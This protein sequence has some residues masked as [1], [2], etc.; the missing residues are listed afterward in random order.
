[1]NNRPDRIRI[2]IA[3]E[4]DSVRQSIRNVLT[5][6]PGLYLIGEANN[7]SEAI[8][9]ACRL[10]PD[11][12][13]LGM[14]RCQDNGAPVLEDMK[15]SLLPIP[16]VAI[17]PSGDPPEVL[18]A[19]RLGAR[20]IILKT[21]VPR[22]LFESIRSVV[23]GH[24]WFD[25]GSIKILMDTLREFLPNGN[26]KTEVSIDFGL[27]PRELDVVAKVADGRSNKD[28]GQ[29]FSISERTVKH[30]LTNIFLKLG[31]SSRLELAMFAVNHDVVKNRA[32]AMV[33]RIEQNA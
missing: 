24:Y 10:K 6:Q 27:T 2:I 20:G 1:M 8:A 25:N 18:N 26:H 31:V 3:D 28:I 15:T 33:R 7:I 13:L 19:F 17:I 21:F 11:V 4:Q 5:F 29:Q 14:Y 32:S 22:V 9:L 12:L 16:T 30:H 23:D